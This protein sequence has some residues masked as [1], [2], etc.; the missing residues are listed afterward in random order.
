MA[1]AMYVQIA[2]DLR[3][4]IKN[5]VPA[6]GKLLPPEIALQKEYGEG[7][8]NAKVSRNTIRDAIALLVLEGLVEK[9]AGQGTFVVEEI[10]PFVTTVS[11]DPNADKGESDLYQSQVER[12]GRKMENTPPRVEIHKSDKAPELGL[13]EGEQV[14]SRHQGRYIDD[15]AYSLQTSFYRMADATKATLLLTAGEIEGGAVAYIERTLGVRQE[16]SQ[17]E[18]FARTA[19]SQEIEFLG[20]PATS[21]AQVIEVRRTAFDGEGRPIRLTVTVYAADRNRLVYKMG[22]VPED[23]YQD[24]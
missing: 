9:K 23:S 6:P 8:P 17:D 21:G 24:I 4:K 12:L 15:K 18:F 1:E 10:I 11:V 3:T 2:N 19:N 5:G 13:G 20:L 7:G 16:G 14:V 22:K